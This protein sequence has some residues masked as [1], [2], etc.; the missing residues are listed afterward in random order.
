MLLINIYIIFGYRE[1][2]IYVVVEV[3]EWYNEM[4]IGLGV[5]VFRFFL[6]IVY[7]F[8]NWIS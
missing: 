4:N 7:L 8:V 3:M 2:F 1:V 5:K 6:I